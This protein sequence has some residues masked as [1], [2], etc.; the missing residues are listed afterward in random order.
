MEYTVKQLSDLA[1]VSGRTLRYYDQIGL[2]SPAYLN[3]S[4]YRIYGKEEVDRLQ[5]ILFYRELGVSL[6]KIQEIVEK[7][8]F[9]EQQALLEHRKQLLE[10]RRQ[11]DVLINN[12]EQTI[13]AKKGELKMTDQEKFAGFKRELIEEN[14]QKYGSEI[15][16]KYGEE[17]VDAA[18]AKLMGMCEQQYAKG[19]QVA[20]EL[21]ALLVDAVD[22][23]DPAGAIGKEI[24]ELHREWLSMYWPKY[25]K[26][27]H[28]GLAEMY[29]HDERFTDYYDQHKKGAAQFLRD[30]IVAY[31][32]S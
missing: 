11:L 20:K 21:I 16:E 1:G 27:A 8:D 28:A 6:Q 14:E 25:S 31:A 26:E 18:N 5:Q 9:K 22:N 30:A 12:V 4:G 19:Q 24:A 17:T 23:E 7:P 10:K 2:L 32:N 13:A 29:I 3:E 15:R